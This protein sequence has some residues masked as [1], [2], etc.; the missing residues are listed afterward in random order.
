MTYFVF[1]FYLALVNIFS[2]VQ[3]IATKRSNKFEF[4]FQLQPVSPCSFQSFTANLSEE[5]VKYSS[6]EILWLLS[7]DSLEINPFCFVPVTK[8][9][10]IMPDIWPEY[11]KYFH[12]PHGCWPGLALEIIQYWDRK[13][14]YVPFCDLLYF[15][16][17]FKESIYKL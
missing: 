4:I 12:Q 10:F 11:R 13:V 17:W 6:V 14:K 5:A 16:L 15:A 1:L 9:L 8:F 3:C 7:F 2:V